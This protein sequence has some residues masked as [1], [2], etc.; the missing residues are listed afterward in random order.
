GAFSGGVMPIIR[1][2]KPVTIH[3]GGDSCRQVCIHVLGTDGVGSVCLVCGNFKIF[4][5]E[6]GRSRYEVCDAQ[7]ENQNDPCK[8]V[9][10]HAVFRGSLKRS[11]SLACRQPIL[12]TP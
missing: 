8:P 11:T 4:I 10:S 7:R 1:G 3:L 9:F 5:F 6:R 12:R 2:T